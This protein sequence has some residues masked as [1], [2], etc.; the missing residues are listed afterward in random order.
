[1][2]MQ[3]QVSKTVTVAAGDLASKLTATEKTTVT[4]LTLT[5][6]IDARDFK[7]MRD[8][9]PVL[10]V[11]DLDSAAIISYSGAN[12]TLNYETTYQSNKIPYC[13]FQND[14]CLL[15]IKLPNTITAIDNYA[16]Y[17]CEKLTTIGELPSSINLIGSYS[18]Y[19]CHSL[20]MVTITEGLET[21]NSYAFSNS[22]AQ[23]IVDVNNPNYSALDGLFFNKDQSTLIQCPTTK[24]GD[25]V[26]PKTV[27]TIGASSF[28]SCS[29]LNSITVPSS[30]KT[31]ETSAFY[32]VKGSIV[33]NADNAYYSSTDGV[34]FNKMQTSILFCPVSK[35]GSYEIPQSVITI[36]SSAFAGCSNL[37]SIT[38]PS[39]VTSIGTSAFSNCKA[40]KTITSN[41]SVPPVTN[42]AFYN[43]NKDSCLIKVSYKSASLYKASNYWKDFKKIEESTS[44]F[45]LDATKK[46]F[47]VLG[48]NDSI[49]VTANVV[50]SVTD[51]QDWININRDVANGK[52]IVTVNPNPTKLLRRGTITVTSVSAPTQLITISQEG[53]TNEVVVTSGNLFTLLTTEE[54]NGTTNLVLNGTIDA[55]DFKTMRDMMPA[56]ANLDLANANI[57]AYTGTEGT[58]NYSTT[59]SANEIPLNAFYNPNTGLAKTGLQTVILPSSLTTIGQSAFSNC[60]GLSSINIPSSV[61][62]IG[63]QVFSGCTQLGSIL[64]PASVSYIEGY[65]F[66]D[67]SASITVDSENSNYSSFN[68]ALFNKTQT[69]LIVCPISKTGDFVIPATVKSIQYYAFRDC[70]ELNSISIPAS[71]TDIGSSAFQNCS[72]L[73]TVDNANTKYSSADGVLFNKDI[74]TLI[75][76]PISK[77]DNYSIPTSVKI[78]GE[79]AFYNCTKLDTLVIPTTVTTIGNYAFWGCSGLTSIQTSATTP[80][81]LS[82]PYN[83]F[84]NIDKTICTLNVPYG[85]KN[86]YAVANQ[87]REFSKIA[88]ESSGILPDPTE[89]SIPASEGR[90]TITIT[91]NIAWVAISDQIWLSVEPGSGENDGQLILS[92]DSNPYCFTRKATITVSGTNVPLQIVT[93]KQEGLPKSVEISAGSL[94]VSL[95]D[96]ELAGTNNLTITGTIDARD[97]KTMRDSMPS[98]SVLDLRGATIVAYNGEE[99]TNPSNYGYSYY[100][101]NAIPQF[102]FYNQ[103]TNTGKTRLQMINMPLSVT[104]IGSNSFTG[105]NGITSLVLPPMITNIG[106]GTFQDCSMLTSINIPSI[107]T[108]EYSC[109]SNCKS[110]K[111]ITIPSSVTSIRGYAFSN[112]DSLTSVVLPSS[113]TTIESGVFRECD[114]LKNV[115]ILSPITSIPNQAFINCS[116]LVSINIPPSVKTIGSDAFSSCNKLDSIQI[117]ASVTF[118]GENAFR[119]FRGSINVDNSNLNYSSADG[120]LFD[121][122]KTKVIQCPTSKTGSF[123]IPS[124]VSSIG[125]SAFYECEGLSEVVIPSSVITIGN[126]AFVYC[127]GLTSIHVYSSVPVDLISS[128]NV[129]YGV[130]KANC[131]LYVPYKTKV[132]YVSADQWKDF[133]NIVEDVEGFSIDK[134]EVN[135]AAEGGKDTI[136]I[137][138]NADWSAT[139]SQT[140]LTVNPTN[141]TNDEELILTATDN[142]YS[143]ARS[144]TLTITSGGNPAQIVS[145]TQKGLPKK[146][147][148]TA[149]GT[150]SS[151][152]TSLELAGITDLTITGFIDARDFKTMRDNMP[153]L[154]VLDISTATIVGY[155]GTAGTAGTS[156]YS[157]PANEIPQKA[158]YIY[159]EITYRSIGKTSLK[160]VALPNSITRIGDNSFSGCTGLPTIE[161]PSMVNTIGYSAFSNCTG[162]KSIVIP[163]SVLSIDYD[164]FSNCTGLISLT[165]SSSLT[166]L[167]SSILSSCTSLSSVIIPESVISIQGSAFYN[168]KALS[169]ITI[170]L[171]VKSIGGSAFGYCA[172]L[173]TIKIPSSVTSIEGY[174]F[175]GCTALK[176]IT[177]CSVYP[178]DLTN[179]NEVFRNVNKSTCKL[180]VPYQ[181]QERYAAANQWKDFLK[182]VADSAGILL[183]P[184]VA[185]FE[186]IGG[187][188]TIHVLSNVS[189]TANSDQ[190]WLTVSPDNAEGD[191]QLILTAV[192]NPECYVRTSIVTVSSTG[193]DSKTINVTQV[194]VPKSIAITSGTLVN[195]LSPQELAGI[196]NL[197]ITGTIDARDFK[198][199]RDNMPLLSVIDLSGASIVAYSGLGGTETYSTTYSANAIPR[200]AFQNKT[201]LV[202]IILPNS[203]ITIEYNAFSQCTGLTTIV[204]PSSL[205]TMRG[206]AFNR[207]TSLTSISI[208]SAV[209]TIEYSVF[210]NCSG[211]TSIYVYPIIPVTLNNSNVF[212]NVNKTNCKL[213][214]PYGSASAYKA[215][216][217]WKDFFDNIIEIKEP[218]ANAGRDSI[219]NEIE[220]YTF[221][222]T[223]SLDPDGG[224]LSYRW[225][226]P[227]GI[228][229][230]VTTVARPSFI[231]PEVTT[232]TKYTFWLVVSNGKISSIPDQVVITVKQVNKAP[233]ANAGPDQTVTEGTTVTFDGSLSSDAD[234]EPIFYEWSAPAGITLNSRYT[235]NP[236]FKTPSI[237]NDTTFTFTL[238]VKDA[239][240]AY[241]MDQVSIKVTDVDNRIVSVQ[242][243]DADSV[244]VNQQTSTI[245]L[246][247]P[248]G[249]NSTTL[250]PTFEISPN[251]TLLPAS[252]TTNDFSSPVIYTVTS[253]DGKVKKTYTVQLYIPTITL[254]R[255]LDSGWNWISLGV[256]PNNSSISGVF[257]SQS[258]AELDYIK[259]TIASSVYYSSSGWFGDLVTIP[260]N[261]L[262]MLK[263][264]EASEFSLTGKEIN[265]TTTSIPISEGWNRIGFCLKG[266]ALI[267]EAFDEN[268][269]PAGELLLKSKDGSA[270]YYPGTGWIGDIDSLRVLNGYMLK[271]PSI[272]NIRYKANS[273]HLKSAQTSV[274]SKND[275]LSK[276]KVYP[277]LYENS[278]IIICEL[279]DEI[280]QNIIHEGDLIIAYSGNDVRGVT[281]ARY[282]PSL[283]RN[284]F[285]LTIFSNN[286]KEKIEFRY[287]Q[288]TNSNEQG[289]S[290]SIIAMANDVYGEAMN[291]FKLH[292]AQSVGIPTLDGSV[293]VYPN[294]AN[295]LINVE[296]S[297]TIVS[298]TI[299]DLTG[300][301]KKVL[302][303]ERGN[304]L[305]INV[306]DFVPGIYMLKIETVQGMVV[307]QLIKSPKR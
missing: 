183:S 121:K 16:F 278:A 102:S 84:Y 47:K 270:I 110:L 114:N 93:V 264:A 117:P 115:T 245:W 106:Q 3:A 125:S 291:P 18:F 185:S 128:T 56:L 219:I 19:G 88:E 100:S 37:N 105:C 67:C 119:Y 107:S 23:L 259:T 267:D 202:S 95:S 62:N 39:F 54:L 7:T 136:N 224:T 294:P 60:S 242:L 8:N 295:E 280:N 94:S 186:A 68:G 276:Y 70:D 274:F 306:E 122:E 167:S 43:V 103:T 162:F 97:F 81:D 171:S 82:L 143:Y 28:Y 15:S 287:K 76:C 49:K 237:A 138:A 160:S 216:N 213:Y 159:N 51:D 252:G 116:K 13:A 248:Y 179:S 126:S 288:L 192:A 46:S 272:G 92:V 191:Q 297:N 279:Y 10:A 25:Y 145:V 149:A 178:I 199:M 228:D 27:T 11:L 200:Y 212:Y 271:A 24:S 79:Y 155:N 34:L 147:N 163:N 168:C 177:A 174:A 257:N 254:S 190:T 233:V 5:G 256:V 182:T 300:R 21:I 72:S 53:Q 75:N 14:T 87:W 244:V 85:T 63:Y 214:V 175:D 127:S 239:A 154:E 205:T 124:T 289:V 207:C 285:I 152:L 286:T 42:D 52:L 4:D 108:I 31:V 299:T 187:T 73:F 101:A 198:T 209:T 150:L 261:E 139:S 90:D 223:G 184:I 130:N 98:L 140:W 277:S 206:S 118:I 59:Y 74:T 231:A 6:T 141:G 153:L 240:N 221:D 148:L 142:P 275:L 234:N 71:V 165:L 158:F 135:Y 69:S 146:V 156:Y 193:V 269:L 132:R 181:T 161:F 292:L 304:S 241:S 9:M 151:K 157:Y 2:I 227:M 196:T 189:W 48:G 66:M 284:V 78:I 249:Y 204:L 232:D 55:R 111:S 129:F 305:S 45:I 188:D 86:R 137:Q 251:A 22:S 91:S 258:F 255:M 303:C 32:N 215:A 220:L 112:C 133:T 104:A 293:R 225:T 229:I 281:E 113:I 96:E 169:S 210:S 65:A 166:T 211:L 61:S 83:V 253:E 173:T 99:G 203:A 197:T 302:T 64:I 262:V 260:Q 144:A 17:G 238:K 283:G 36:G 218:V 38:I 301:Q 131:K 170:P 120:V 250:S 266:N 268:V 164:A 50:W 30:V 265:P 307:Q 230:G 201:C 12:G 176:S 40:L 282:I 263:K 236:T 58:Y 1:M 29:A 246:Y 247:M 194:G 226:A 77:T 208:P 273:A 57:L 243:T 172:G 222:G 195:S 41:S 298:V 235:A 180:Y 109:F 26:V 134:T 44:G 290:E 217:Y 20:N 296:S 80:V 89:I 35:T 33:V 123:L